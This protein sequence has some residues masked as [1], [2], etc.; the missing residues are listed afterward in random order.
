MSDEK[1][2]VGMEG[3]DRPEVLGSLQNRKPRSVMNWKEPGSRDDETRLGEHDS[4]DPGLHLVVVS[5]RDVLGG[6]E[7]IFE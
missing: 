6:S 7:K 1:L 2:D 5:R 4:V 3:A